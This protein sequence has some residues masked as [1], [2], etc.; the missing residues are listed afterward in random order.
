MGN[1]FDP[2]HK[3]LGIPPREQPPNH[4]RLLGISLFES[5]PDV[6]DAAA[7][8]QATYLQSCATGPHVALSQKI[9]NEVAA[10]RLCLLNREKKAEYDKR[11]Q[12]ALDQIGVQQEQPNSAASDLQFDFT[13]VAPLASKAHQPQPVTKKPPPW[14][15]PAVVGGGALVCL[16]VLATLLTGGKDESN[17]TKRSSRTTKREVG[18]VP[19][20]AEEKEISFDLGNGVKLEMILV[21]RG[22]F[23]MGSPDSDDNA[24]GDEKPQHQVRINKPFYLGKYKVTQEQWEAVMDYNPS[25]FKGPKNPMEEVDWDD[26]QQFLEKLNT[27]I[28]T[29]GSKFVLPTEAQWE[30]ACRAGSTTR[31]FFGDEKS[32]LGEYAWYDANSKTRTHP[33]GEKRPNAWGLYDMHGN[34]WEWCQ[35]FYDSDYYLN[36][37]AD[38][39]SAPTAASGHVIRGGEWG[40]N[41]R[42][43]R[44]AIRSRSGVRNSG[45]GLR[46]SLVPTDS[47]ASQSIPPTDAKV[48]LF[49]GKTL[50]GW[51]LRD[52]D[53]PNCWSAQ[54]GELVCTPQPQCV[55]KNLVTDQLFRDFELQLEFLMEDASNSGVYLRGLYEVQLYDDNAKLLGPKGR[56][57]AIFG[58]VAPSEEAYLGP[59]KWNTLNVKLIGPRVSVTMNGKRIID[60]AYVMV[61]TDREQILDVNMGDPGPIMLQW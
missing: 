39:P 2:Y 60:D 16:G 56:C 35:D 19:F 42:G 52:T 5:D 55:G 36:C 6:I 7:S 48:S 21:P 32:A 37:P 46:V 13:T 54:D 18:V 11:L 14:L 41:A 30:Y 31:Y 28:G 10:A 61:P 45:L 15:I 22:E 8:K 50:N 49:D 23:M 34:V 25:H 26:C 59:G 53:G 38:D 24:E 47:R 12:A 1:T 33:V 40:L 27:K 3:W 43:C 17:Q 4:Y 20:D 29:R 57:G 58:Q 51:H 9:L 44:S